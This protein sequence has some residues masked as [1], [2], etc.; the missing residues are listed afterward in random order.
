MP[1]SVQHAQRETL[2][3]NL[4]RLQLR[5]TTGVL[6]GFDGVFGR[7]SAH[8]LGQLAV[9]CHVDWCRIDPLHVLG[10]ATA[11]VYFHEKLDVCHICLLKIRNRCHCDN[12][13]PHLFLHRH[14]R[15]FETLAA[16]HSRH[17]GL[18]RDV[19][20]PHDGHI[21]CDRNVV[22]C[23][24]SFQRSSRPVNS[25]KSRPNEILMVLMTATLLDE[26]RIDHGAFDPARTLDPRADIA[27]LN[28][29]SGS[30]PPTA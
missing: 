24:F 19:I 10:S 12:L 13:F 23:G 27:E 30:S 14:P 25:R 4:H 9:G 6:Q 15:R 21:R 28:R 8:H 1:G 16:P 26:F 29:L 22:L 20:N 7:E 11:S 2:G 18:S 5:D 3:P 17:R